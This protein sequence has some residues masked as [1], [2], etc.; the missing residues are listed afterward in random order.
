MDIK[1]LEIIL[2]DTKYEM[3]IENINPVY[4]HGNKY[5]NLFKIGNENNGYFA[6]KIYENNKNLAF[7]SVESMKNI[8]DK[9]NFINKYKDVI[10]I[11]KYK[12]FISDWLNGFQPTL[13][14]RENLP[15][16]FY[17]LGIFNKQ[18]ITKKGPF[19][20]MYVDYNYFDK[21]ED[22]ID[23]EI[24]YHKKYIQNIVNIK[25][26]EKILSYLKK[27][28]SCII[29]EDMNTGNLFITDDG[30]YK[31]IDTE[32][33]IKGLNLYQF[34]KINYFGFEE[35]EWYNITEEAKDCYIAYFDAL[36]IKKEEA[37]KQIK[38]FELLQ[39]LRT[40]TFN[41]VYSLSNDEEIKRRIKIVMEKEKYI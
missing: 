1:E 39:V 32:W 17:L 38:A 27:G 19:T 6:L 15:N 24:N 34:E 3:F 37:N 33:I 18:N 40:N 16:F 14:N 7:C 12:I 22:L 4:A 35:N 28:V 11:G 9:D 5:K 20:S 8:V 29:S 10:N 13:N 26:I 23:Y 30:N 2:K 41:K 21:I 31:I 36:E 25:Q